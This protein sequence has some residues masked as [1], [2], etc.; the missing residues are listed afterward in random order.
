MHAQSAKLI[1]MCA[2]TI[3]N[4]QNKI[5]KDMKTKLFKSMN[6]IRCVSGANLNLFRYTAM[7]AML[8]ML[9]AGNAWAGHG[10]KCTAKL[11]V[12]T[13]TGSGSVY[14]ATTSS[15]TSGSSSV[16]A[17]CGDSDSGTHTR[18]FYAFA[19]PADGY[20]FLGWTESATSTA[21]ADASN[22]K[23]VTIT[24][25][26]HSTVTKTLYA[27][28]VEKAK[29][30]ITFEAP[31]NGTY[32]IAVNGGSAETVSSADVVKNNVEGVV[33]T[34]TPASGY[35][36][37]GWYKLNSSGEFVD[38]ISI[39]S[40][41]EASFT[42]SETIQM[43]ARFV[44][45]SLGKFILKGSSTEYYGLKAATVAAG[46]SG[47]IVPV[48]EQTVVDG[49]DLLPIDNGKY[50]IKS[51]ATLLIPYSSANDVL[52]LPKQV[53]TPQTLRAHKTL[54]LM[55]GVNIEV[56]G[57]I[58]IGGQAMAASGSGSGGHTGYTTG[59]CGV[60][61]MSRGGHIELNDKSTLYCWGFV[62]G[63]D[64]DQGNNTVGVGTITANFGATVWENFSVG[65]WR[66]GT[67]TT[68]FGGRFF[69]FQ[70]YF[71]QNIEIPAT[72]KHGSSDWCYF[73][74]NATGGPYD[75]QF[76]IIGNSNC[77][78]KLQNDQSQ[79]RKWY[80]P[81][82]DLICY[83]LS[84][85]AVMDALKIKISA[86]GFT[87]DISSDD[88]DLPIT[89]NMHIVMTNCI[90]DLTKPM[91]V[92]PGAVVEIKDDAIVT[93][94]TNIFLYD[95]DEWGPWITGKY[96]RSN[97][98]LTSHKSRGDGSSNAQLDDAKFIVD[99]TVTIDNSSGRLYATP[100][101]ADIMGNGGG[102][103]TYPSTLSSNSTI[104]W[105]KGA[106][107]SGDGETGNMTVKQANLHNEDESYTKSVK[108]TTFHNVNSRWFEAAN[109]DVNTSTHVYDEFAYISS[110]AVSGPDGDTTHTNAV[111]A[112]D[113]TGLVAGM[114]WCNVIQDATCTSIYNAT[115]K[116]HDTE[117]ANIRYTYQSSDWLQLLKISEGLYNGSNDNLYA[118]E[119]C[120]LKS[121]GAV[122]ENCLY[123]VDDTKKAY[124]EGSLVELTKN[125]EDEAWH[126][127][128]NAEEYYVCF[129]GC[130]WHSAEKY[131][132][133]EKA[134]IVDE[135]DY[136]WYNDA[137]K[138]VEYQEPFFFDYD[139]Q[140]VQVFYEYKNG[141]WAIATPKVRVKDDIETREFFTF[142]EA[143]NIAKDKRNVI[144]TI[145]DDV[146]SKS[147]ALS[148]TSANTAYTLD[149]NGHKVSHTITGSGTAAVLNMIDLD[150]AGTTLTITDNSGTNNGELKLIAAPTTTNQTK[151]WHGIHVTNGSL[152]MNAGTLKVEDNF[153]K[154]STTNSGRA[155]GVTIEPGKSF[156]MNGGTIDV[157]SSYNTIGIHVAGS[158]SAN[159]TVTLNKGTINA[160]TTELNAPRGVYA[161]GG[162]TSIKEGVI[163]NVTSQTTDARGIFVEA[164]KGGY[165]GTLNMSGGEVNVRTIQHTVY[166]VYVNRA[167]TDNNLTVYKAVANISGGTF[168]VTS[169]TTAS[170]PVTDGIRSYGTTTISE[171]PEFNVTATGTYAYGVR[172]HDG[173]TTINGNPHFTVKATK[174]AYGIYGVADAANATT[175]LEYHSNVIING[176]VYDVSTTSETTAMGACADA[177]SPRVIASG[178]YAG[179]YYSSATVTVNDGTFNVTTKTTSAYGVYSGRSYSNA[180]AEPNTFSNYNYSTVNVHG[181]TFNVTATTKTAMGVV[182]HGYTNI[183][184]GT[185][186]VRATTSTA[187]G[188]RGYAGKTTV[189]TTNNPIF[190]VK[191]KT[192]AYGATCGEAP[193]SK[194]GLTYNGELEIN[195]GT[196]TVA[197]TNSTTAYGILVYAKGTPITT[198]H[199]SNADYYAGNYASAG[200]ATI[201]GGTFNVTSA[202]TTAYGVYMSS[203]VSE[204]GAS[205]YATATATPTCTINGGTFTAQAATDAAYGAFVS[206]GAT[207]TVTDGIIKGKLT[208]VAADKFAVGAYIAATGE[209]NATGG[210]FEA[211][212]AK[213]GLTKAQ[214]S[215][216]C[217]LYSPDGTATI[218]AS[219][220]T[221]KGELKSTYLS[222]GGATTWSGG[223]YG[224]YARTTTPLSLTN[225]TIIGN[226]AY[227][228]GFGLRFANTPA[229]VRNCNITVTTTK[230]YNY[231][232]FVG[233]ADCDVKLYDCNFTC[234]SGTTYAYGIYAYNGATYAEDCEI[235]AIV[236][237]T[238]ASSVGNSNL[239]GVLVATGKTATLKGCTI[240]AIG[241]G[242]YSN[243]GYGVYVDGTA[244]LDNCDVAVSNINDGAYALFNTSNTTLLNVASGKYKASATTNAASTNGTAAAAKQVI[245]GGYYSTNSNLSKYTTAPY[246]VLTLPNT[247]T[248]YANGYRYKVAEAYTVTFM[249]GSVQLQSDY[250]ETGVKPVYA[251]TPTKA[252][253]AQY[254]YTFDGWTTNAEGTGTVYTASTLPIVATAA[255]TYFAH[256]SKTENKYTVT[257][258]TAAHGSVSPAAVSNIGCETAS[259]DITATPATGYSFSGWT[260]PEGVT[261]ATGYNASSN[262]IHIHA[263]TTGKSITANF[264]PRTDINYTVKHW[265]QNLDNNEYTEY[266]SEGKTGTTATPTAAAAK[267]YTGFTAQSFEQ[268]TIAGNG[269][270]IVNIYYNRNTYTI[271]WVDGNGT[272]IKTDAN[273]KYGATPEYAGETPTKTQ[274]N[275]Y[276][277]TFTGWEPAITT[278][279]ADATY[280]AQFEQTARPYTITWLNCNGVLLCNTTSY[281]NEKPAYPTYETPTYTDAENRKYQFTGWSPEIHEVNSDVNVYTAQYERID[282]LV[283]TAEEPI[284]ENTT[285][286]TTTVRVE[287]KLNVA[288]D[289]TLTTDD[290]ILEATPSSSGEITGEGT[291]TATRAYFDFSNGSEGFKA[292]TWYA[293][294]VPWQ[295]NVPAY[296]K[297]HNGVYITNDGEHYTQQELGRSFDLIYY[298]GALRASEGHSDACWKYIEDDASDKHIMYPGRAYMIYLTSDAQTIRF[299]R[300]SG[301]DLITNTLAVYAFELKTGKNKDAN[302]NGI[303]NPATYHAYINANVKNY[304][305]GVLN[306]GQVY[307]A[308]TRTYSL[309]NMSDNNLVVGQPI[310]VQVTATNESVVAYATHDAAFHAPRRANAQGV[311]M[312][313]YEVMFAPNEGEVTD[314]IIVRLNEE[315]EENAYVVG[316]DLVKMGV[317]DIVPQMWVDRYESK[318]CINT[319]A[320]VN[321]RADYP[322]GIS[323]QQ[324][325]AY[326]LFIDDQPDDETMLYLTYDGEAI[327]NLSYGGYVVN[328]EKGTNS[329]Y[330]LRIVRSPK[331]TTD[332]EEATI[333]NGEAVRKVVIEDKVFIIRN[334]QIYG[335]D[336]RLAK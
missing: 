142:H 17:D 285:L 36:F 310:F 21:G 254:S 137:W 182:T 204:S 104:R 103:I 130:T 214:M 302:W 235:N 96:F 15:A 332:I 73:T 25:D 260:L 44:P 85:T 232:L 188:I 70:N 124:V 282:D 164:N 330:G 152:I 173:T 259:G 227:Q 166:G 16:S 90:M 244:N 160:T 245:T 268:G 106:T 231:G 50:I 108:S 331:V 151:R 121:L 98:N 82:T 225:C 61:D 114:K 233:G 321:N 138:K 122:D 131:P 51:G 189:N 236:Q 216:A 288:A 92:Q 176:G 253:D 255:A 54:I 14:A 323:V 94:K 247:H 71:V 45:T 113:K 126:N 116:L 209:L 218:S 246:Q 3:N 145:L 30:N 146:T 309:V 211:E 327:W 325:G 29:V 313:R 269:S 308:E 139:D 172:T 261:A 5:Q 228:G 243:N 296:D 226:S 289:K 140:H 110:G 324:S 81:T 118:L 147:A 125:E 286:T 55:A 298:D 63:Q 20:T 275:S 311:S 64:M 67:A 8:L 28:F 307:N 56:N 37:A 207:L 109:K 274:D 1:Y 10:G 303:A 38:D 237:R 19:T 83:E 242:K 206:N 60:L 273:V 2:C 120:T 220:A 170:T 167:I 7:V 222:N 141:A 78:F 297:A 12:N 230:A 123:D 99:G 34:A 77:L 117:A 95:K 53:T 315:K 239:Y 155:S 97:S 149:L 202:T 119:G 193:N 262:P 22:P 203:P 276:S 290:L 299:E 153:P 11:Q 318:M 333:L 39:A 314:R 229:E 58:C 174:N 49:S 102:T 184:G 158:T 86:L 292:K 24:S 84:G 69:P 169:T 136:I 219:N 300:K 132:N 100:G 87:I 41:Y 76:A 295:V 212:A 306:V 197:T 304:S 277:Y 128:A 249:N 101:G 248:E 161:A 320:P 112:P 183:D 154:N 294:A 57:S 46:G 79:V 205:G 32:T 156:T 224:F 91:I 180:K 301:T 201:N 178:E 279:T 271:T 258:S 26:N 107:T 187:Y 280:T 144:I 221:F 150:A 284:E 317:S 59:D 47:V 210:T 335:I 175:G 283:I 134:Y 265:Q 234:T 80:D 62:K 287:G 157:E 72:Y 163:I 18:T 252:A 27:H 127:T 223:A 334:D 312:T 148:L 238:G 213:S 68:N 43:G 171:S 305:S 159:A 23:S 198:T 336:G 215:Y 93:L 31:S 281:W 263:T 329:H 272:T 256:Y 208:A 264:V 40:P 66:G 6:I 129:A 267:S 105:Y 88:Y 328:L 251:G 270:T 133:Q 75:T 257:V 179:T 293:V 52:A 217:G 240:T 241:S 266:E 35:A 199:A 111:Y 190:D 115:Q 316:Q 196:F 291:V 186:T 89:S 65:D 135:E 200:T 191:T 185:F 9:G 13:G 168:N 250:V 195:G 192:V 48:A 74:L 177:V 4:K 165:F 322:L 326:D 33:L 181:G 319:V 42:E 162:T 278:V 194:S 143:M